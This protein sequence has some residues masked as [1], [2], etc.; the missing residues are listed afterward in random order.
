MERSEGGHYELLCTPGLVKSVE[1]WYIV[2]RL[3][4][5]AQPETAN[6]FGH[7]ALLRVRLWLFGGGV[8]Q[9]KPL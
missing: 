4:I 9:D 3:L 6:R 5:G 2:L 8:K 1:V 7:L